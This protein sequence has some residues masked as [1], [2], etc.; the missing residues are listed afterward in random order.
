VLQGEVEPAMDQAGDP[1]GDVAAEAS[2][3]AADEDSD[4]VQRVRALLVA[5]HAVQQQ[6]AEAVL[7]AVR[8]GSVALYPLFNMAPRVQLP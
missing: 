2:A 4:T 8:S 7:Q 5:E 1:E 6:A 3:T